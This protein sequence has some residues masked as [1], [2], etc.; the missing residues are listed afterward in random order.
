MDLS[1]Y[2][3]CIVCR[4][5]RDKPL[6][7]QCCNKV[8]CPDCAQ[9][10]TNKKSC[11]ICKK[12]TKFVENFLVTKLVKIK[13][14]DGPIGGNASNPYLLRRNL[15]RP[16]S[17]R[18]LFDNSEPSDVFKIT[19]LTLED[20]RITIEV[21]KNYK[22]KDVKKK[23]REIEGFSPRLIHLGKQ[24]EDHRYISDYNIKKDSVVHLV[25]RY[26]GS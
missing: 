7:S 4:D 20:K 8:F 9:R 25:K 26:H 16:S 23:I 13:L 22:V 14:R 2:L 10:L 3:K 6:V 18:S 15:Y 17:L 1:D 19:I 5:I 11:S 12:E 21:N 24:L